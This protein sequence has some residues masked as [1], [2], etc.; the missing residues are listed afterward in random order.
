MG[1]ILPEKREVDSRQLKVKSALFIARWVDQVLKLGVKV[2]MKRLGG[3]EE[4]RKK[5]TVQESGRPGKQGRS[6][7]RPT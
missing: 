2:G 3:R 4:E 1:R 5:Q 6:M 7:L